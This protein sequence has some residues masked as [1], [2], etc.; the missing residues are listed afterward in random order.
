MPAPR[1]GGTRG[2]KLGFHI[3]FNRRDALRT[4]RMRSMSVSEFL[5]FSILLNAPPLY[6]SPVERVRNGS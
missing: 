5:N 3:D 2:R 1:A 4:A 6:A